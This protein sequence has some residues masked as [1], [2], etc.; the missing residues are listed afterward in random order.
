MPLDSSRD[1]SR[2]VNSFWQCVHLRI[3]AGCDPQES[4]RNPLPA[5]LWRGW[6]RVILL[7]S[8][9]PSALGIV[10]RDDFSEV[11]PF[12]VT[13]AA[14]A[15][16]YTIGRLKSKMIEKAFSWGRPAQAAIEKEGP[17]R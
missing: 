17:C 14:A 6:W 2:G 9:Y 11:G 13:V 16:G 15:R 4:R 12:A 8:L 10:Y 1:N 5:R 7:Q 3:M